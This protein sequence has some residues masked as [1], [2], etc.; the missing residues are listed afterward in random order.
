MRNMNEASG[1]GTLRSRRTK[2]IF[3]AYWV[4]TVA[5]GL[6]LPRGDDMAALR[7]LAHS[8]IG[9]LR[10]VVQVASRSFDPG[11]VEVFAALSLG[12]ALALAVASCFWIPSGSGKFFPDKKAKAVFLLAAGLLFTLALGLALKEY[13]SVGLSGGRTA[14]FLHLG[15]ST[16]WGV[17]TILNAWFGFSQ[18]FFFV[19]LRA[20]ATTPVQRN[21]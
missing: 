11:F 19:A 21:S 10:G 7:G 20:G 3:G 17:L 15:S 12:S 6:A 5:L 18:L 1:N 14:A 13:S 8:F 9:G 4:V 2:Q 16:K